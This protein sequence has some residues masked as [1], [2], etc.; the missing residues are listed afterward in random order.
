MNK[1]IFF[2]TQFCFLLLFA[3]FAHAQN[4]MQARIDSY[5]SSAVNGTY[6]PGIVAIVVDKEG[7]LYEGAFGYK[8]VAQGS[9]MQTDSI[10]RLA[11]MTKPI[12]SVAVQQL[13]E[14]GNIGL[15]DPISNYLPEYR[16]KQ[17]IE[18]YDPNS[19]EYSTR[20]ASGEITIRNLLAHTA[21]FG[22]TF[23][24]NV[25]QT[26]TGTSGRLSTTDLPL[27]HDPGSRWTYGESTS[28]LGS[29]VEKVSGVS[30][31]QYFKAQIFTPLEMND[32]F[33][34]VPA[35][36]ASRVVTRHRKSGDTLNEIPN[37]EILSAEVLGDGGLFSTGPE[38]VKFIQM[39]LNGGIGNNGSRVLSENSIA[40]MGENHIGEIKVELQ[41]SALPAV[42]EPFPL[43][44]GVDTFGLGFQVTGQHNDSGKRSPGS[45]SW[46]GIH[47]T[48]FWIDPEKGIGAVLLLQ[49]IPFYDS[50]AVELL[51][52]FERLVYESQ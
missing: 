47:N 43:G 50:V 29:L 24:S 7:V 51:V 40:V 22:Y 20:S 8:N 33:F 6:I 39:F 48:E 5:L 19:G 32:T 28:V 36:K 9:P 1:R 52:E 17:V 10:F 37:P 26:I 4:P 45:L 38:Y 21:G 41:P 2:F 18:N 27:L 44:A 25:L 30:L 12:T 42:S 31:D 3:S 35:P 15:D 11:S 49:Y 16:D 14:S 13:I 34:T 46:A 23:S